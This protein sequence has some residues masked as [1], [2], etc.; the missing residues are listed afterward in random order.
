MHQY[1]QTHASLVCINQNVTKLTQ[2]IQIREYNQPNLEFSS[3]ELRISYGLCQSTP[4]ALNATYEFD[5]TKI[6]QYLNTSKFLDKTFMYQVLTIINQ[7][8]QKNHLSFMR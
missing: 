2:Y 8:A 6:L 1:L 4:H 5:I 3:K 7:R